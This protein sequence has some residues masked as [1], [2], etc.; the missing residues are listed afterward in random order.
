MYD[1]DDTLERMEME[2]R[3]DGGAFVWVI[4]A[5]LVGFGLA[6]YFHH[7]KP[8]KAVEHPAPPCQVVSH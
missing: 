1:N 4:L 8:T 7:S 5:L 3:P 2:G 6:H